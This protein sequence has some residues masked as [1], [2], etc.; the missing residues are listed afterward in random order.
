MAIERWLVPFVHPSA[1][2]MQ[3]RAFLEWTI[4]G[5]SGVLAA[6]LGVP[7]FLYL[8]D[9]RNRPGR[10]SDW[11]TVAKLSELQEGV[12]REIVIRETRRDAWNLHPDDVV[13][14]V[15]L[16][17]RPNDKVDAFTTICPH[18]GCSVD[19][20]PTGFLCP[21]H[22]GQFDKDGKR[23]IPAQGNNPAPRDMD[24]LPCEIVALTVGPDQTPDSQVK[25]QYKRFKTSLDKPVEDT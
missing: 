3:R 17:R 2:G 4:H 9:A 7:A 25:V 1:D 24:K 16:V 11:R 5:L 20:T 18:L 14:R 13:G 23:V 8:I 21:C 19:R 12:P 6:V 15:W 10:Q 22:G